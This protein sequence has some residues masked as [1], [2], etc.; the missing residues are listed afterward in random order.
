MKVTKY[1]HACLVVEELNQRL[2]IDPGMFAATL[3][4]DLKDVA[5]VVITHEHGDHLDRRLLNNLLANNPSAT[6]FAPEEVIASLQ[7]IAVKMEIAEPGVSHT[8]G[9]FALD[10]YGKDHAVIYDKVPCQNVGVMV[11]G[12]LYYPGDSFTL[13]K[14]PVAVLAVPSGAPWMK[15]AEAMEFIKKVKPQR[16]FPTHNAVY[17]RE[18]SQFAD[19]WLSQA[20][21]DAGA[22]YT[23][24]E[25]GQSLDL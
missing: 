1:E 20:A 22:A 5:A 19:S 2:V 7:D 11:N 6:I 4:V 9:S 17:S 12:S 8:A 24:L 10:F 3:P 23:V 15:V 14:R 25:T 16:A 13:P 21:E 18:G